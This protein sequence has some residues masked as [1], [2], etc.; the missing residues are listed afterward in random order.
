[1]KAEESLS[2]ET[3]K[4]RRDSQLSDSRKILP[5]G[6]GMD[7]MIH[8]GSFQSAALMISLLPLLLVRAASL[9]LRFIE[10]I[11]VVKDL[12]GSKATAL[13]MGDSQLCQEDHPNI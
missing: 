2:L 10:L 4:S 9:Q 12:P 11:L 13:P 3:L 7:Q 5:R 8:L 1:M 6:R